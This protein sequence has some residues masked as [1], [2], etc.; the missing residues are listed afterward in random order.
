MLTR[1]HMNKDNVHANEKKSI[2]S[3]DIYNV[4]IS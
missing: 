1:E 3:Q 2:D 4:L